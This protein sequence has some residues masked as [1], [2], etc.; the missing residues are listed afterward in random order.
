[1]RE[2]SAFNEHYHFPCKRKK[3]TKTV[4]ELLINI[5]REVFSEIGFEVSI[6]PPEEN[7]VDLKVFRENQLVL[8]AE[9][10]NWSI[11]S[12][13][14]KNRER[15]ITDNLNQFNCARVLIHT[16]PLS[17]L[18]KFSENGISLIAIGYQILPRH[19]YTFFKHKEQVERRN[20]YSK[21]VVMDIKRLI[22]NSLRNTGIA[23]NIH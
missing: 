11:G 18:N 17:P 8:V 16:V 6:N 14:T 4:G 22:I 23:C 2:D 1:M 12:R 9:V 7:S 19:Y 13:L 20:P 15:Q 10:L 5:L 3:Y 21:Q